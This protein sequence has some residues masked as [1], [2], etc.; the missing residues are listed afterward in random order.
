MVRA[1][2][3]KGIIRVKMQ[4]AEPYATSHPAIQGTRPLRV[5]LVEDS[6][7]LREHLTEALS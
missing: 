1:L 3:Q 5:F 2:H 7:V 4:A 6:P